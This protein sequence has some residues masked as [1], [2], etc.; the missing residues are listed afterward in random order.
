MTTSHHADGPGGFLAPGPEALR[1]CFAND[2]D[3]GLTQ[4]GEIARGVVLS[5]EFMPDGTAAIA[6]RLLGPSGG[7][8]PAIVVTQDISDVIA[9]WRGLGRD[10]DL[11]LYLRDASGVM[12]P[13]TPLRGDIVHARR[14]GSP[15]SGRRPRFLARRKIPPMSL[16]AGTAKAFRKG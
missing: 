15:L 10:L 12:T 5:T 14:K 1:A 6:I 4:P 3:G 13:V 9:E 11:P 7:L 16:V 2:N 8:S